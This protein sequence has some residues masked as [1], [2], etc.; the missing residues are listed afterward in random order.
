M[1][2]QIPRA[3]QSRHP[4]AILKVG[5]T[6][7][8]WTSWT[9]EHTGIYKAGTI[10]IT[11]PAKF[12]EW[13][14]WTQ[15]TEI[16]VDVYAGFPNDPEVFSVKDLTL[17]MSARIDKLVLDP[18]TQV[19]TLSGRDLTSF[20][21]DSKSDAKYQNMKSSDIILSMVDQIQAI[22]GDQ[23]INAY[24]KATSKVVGTYYNTDHVNMK[25][26]DSMWTLMTYLAQHEGLQCFVLGRTLYFGEFGGFVSNEP[27]GIEFQPPTLERPYPVA[28]AERLKFEH[29]LT[30]SGDIT[31]TVRSYHG[32]KNAAYSATAKA[33]GGMKV[34]MKGAKVAQTSQH[35]DYTYPNKT[36]DQ[37]QKIADQILGDISK[38][39]LL[40]EATVPGDVLVYPWTPVAVTGTGTMFDT[41]YQ[42]STISRRFD[43]NGF[44]MNLNCRTTPAQET[45]TL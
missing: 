7:I 2:N 25:S 27:Y 5:D 34:G 3:G 12:G 8:K 30:I 33:A 35:Y 32:Q 1:I 23:S 39:E 19:I 44:F 10:G 21:T 45:V 13:P 42:I 17:L 31:V 37:C 15:Q 43:K 4:R 16:I 20:F 40:M 9:I 24:V 28:N 18:A 6:E 41:T 26:E 29:D 38:H 22:H 11:V 14:M 36:Q